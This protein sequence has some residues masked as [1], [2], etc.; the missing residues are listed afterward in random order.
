MITRYDV[1]YGNHYRLNY[2]HHH[3]LIAVDVWENGYYATYRKVTL[4]YIKSEV[5]G[6][7][8]LYIE[9][10]KFELSKFDRYDELWYRF[11]DS[12]YHHTQCDLD[13]HYDILDYVNHYRNDDEPILCHFYNENKPISFDSANKNELR[14][15]Y[16]C[17]RSRPDLVE[18]YKIP[19]PP[20]RGFDSSKQSIFYIHE[21]T[22]GSYI[23]GYKFGISNGDGY[24]RLYNQN[25]ES[26][27]TIDKK[28]YWVLDG[29]VA[30][31]IE[32]IIKSQHTKAFTKEEIPDGYTE[33]FLPYAYESVMKL[34]DEIIKF[35]E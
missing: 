25:R 32:T 12:P 23:K 34:V 30:R 19:I 11:V 14:L 3:N 21:I 27:Y 15:L 24:S 28:H 8:E 16:S 26:I 7:V 9:S 20:K 22:E 18:M 31:S 29:N 35:T 17:F 13:L 1:K 10:N 6:D 5:N 2:D 4:D 33:T